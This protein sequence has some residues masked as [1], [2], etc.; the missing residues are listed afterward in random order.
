MLLLTLTLAQ[1]VLSPL[2]PLSVAGNWQRA[3]EKAIPLVNA[4]TLLCS[5]LNG[6]PPVSAQPFSPSSHLPC[7][8]HHCL[9]HCVRGGQSVCPTAQSNDSSRGGISTCLKPRLIEIILGSVLIIIH[10]ILEVFFYIQQPQLLNQGS[11]FTTGLKV[12][13]VCFHPTENSDFPAQLYMLH[14]QGSDGMCAMAGCPGVAHCCYT[15][16][17]L[18]AAFVDK[19]PIKKCLWNMSSKVPECTALFFLVTAVGTA[20]VWSCCL[21]LARCSAMQ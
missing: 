3:G 21:Q 7:I 2:G 16:T 1:S 10:K 11:D 8:S 4:Q 15:I 19:F 5:C 18:V 17:F 14:C 20:K 12:S 9:V 6:S 13:S